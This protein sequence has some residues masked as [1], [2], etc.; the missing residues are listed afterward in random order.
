MS[1]ALY[2]AYLIVAALVGLFVI[3]ALA[4][5]LANWR[6]GM[7]D[8]NPSNRDGRVRDGNW[9]MTRDRALLRIGQTLVALAALGVAIPLGVE[10]SLRDPDAVGIGLFGL[11]AALAGWCLPWMVCLMAALVLVNPIR[12]LLRWLAADTNS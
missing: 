12:D 7:G 6:P 1:A 5:N 11:L 10:G 2:D 9:A 3:A 8:D 4:A